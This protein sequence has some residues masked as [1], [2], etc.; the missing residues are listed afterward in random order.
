LDHRRC[1]RHPGLRAIGAIDEGHKSA[2]GC[3]PSALKTS[4]DRDLSD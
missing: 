2:K 3:H 1:H 4:F